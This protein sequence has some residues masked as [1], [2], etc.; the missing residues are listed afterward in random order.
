MGA[1][2]IGSADA[3]MADVEVILLAGESLLGLGIKD[4]TVDINVPSMA[5]F[6][7]SDMKL[8]PAESNMLCRR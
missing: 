6:I 2:L 5:Q 8:S 3:A 1:E 4:L 7:C